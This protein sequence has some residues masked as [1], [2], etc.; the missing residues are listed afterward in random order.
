VHLGVFARRGGGVGVG[1][2]RARDHRVE[3]AAAPRRAATPRVACPTNPA[4]QLTHPALGVPLSWVCSNKRCLRG[5]KSFQTAFNHFQ[6]VPNHL[7]P[8]DC[9][10]QLPNRFKTL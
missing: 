9:F 4:R 5:F 3:Q 6:T 2:Q 10:K 8:S 7:K 1:Q